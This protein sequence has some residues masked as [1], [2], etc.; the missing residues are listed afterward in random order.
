[1]NETRPIL[2]AIMIFIMDFLYKIEM[3]L[4]LQLL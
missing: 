1:M 2:G 4:A 3:G